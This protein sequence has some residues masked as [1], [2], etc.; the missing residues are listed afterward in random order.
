MKAILFDIDGV[1]YNAGQLI[2]GAAEAVRAIQTRGIPHRFVTNTSTRSRQDLVT[3]LGR[4]GIETSAEHLVTPPYAAARWLRNQEPGAVALLVRPSA[5][6]EFQGLPLLPDDVECGADYVVIGDLGEAWDFRTLN[7]AFRLLHSNPDAT[8]VALGM[9][10]YW[11][12][13][14]G[15]LLDVAPFVVALEYATER[16]AVVLG[17]PAAPFFQS[18]LDDLSLPANEVVMVGDDVITDVEAAQQVGIRGIL[19][20]MGKFRPGDLH[21]GIQPDAILESVAALPVWWDAQEHG[22]V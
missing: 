1:L 21:R 10:I 4:F 19:V 22:R 14:G 15:L 18:A 13:P 9:S 3:R 11:H 2:P 6:E 12:G 16:R 5:A 7:R 8:L 20:R 17:K